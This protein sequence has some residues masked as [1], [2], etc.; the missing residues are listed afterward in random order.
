MKK[1]LGF[2]ILVAISFTVFVSLDANRAR[3]ATCEISQIFWRVDGKD[4]I[5]PPGVMA[6]GSSVKVVAQFV[7][8][9]Q[10]GNQPYFF[11]YLPD[12]VNKET[13][14][15]TPLKDGTEL[16]SADFSFP[17]KGDYYFQAGI[18]VG[19]SEYKSPNSSKISVMNCVPKVIFDA[20]PKRVDSLSQTIKLTA[21][22]TLTDQACAMTPGTVNFSFYH[23]SDKLFKKELSEWSAYP[24]TRN[25]E[26]TIETTAGSLGYSTSQEIS[27][28]VKADLGFIDALTKSPLSLIGSTT[29][30]SSP[31]KVGVGVDASASKKYACKNSQCVE[32]AQGS[33][34]GLQMCQEKCV[35]GG[36]GPTTT[37]YT[38]NLLN[39]IGVENFQ[40]LIN[41]I[42]KWIFNLAI[43]IAVIIIIYAGV[44]MLT[45]GGVPARFQKGAKALWYAVLG[46][47]V[48]LIGKGFVTLI[49]SILNLRNK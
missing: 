36:G 43:P 19:G 23:N 4:Y 16:S 44:L 37:Q 18:K 20:N 22:V 5:Q 38:F 41:I 14:N 27:F 31:V 1:I 32:D 30:I 7:N 46:L 13:V 35:A 15:T 34:T 29:L 47:A 33:Y 21:K 9:N 12:G 11:I 40:D 26:R 24:F 8:C 49:Q 2:A 6:V 39:P 42:G 28:Y 25:E 3:G 45:A 10:A 48:V 17:I